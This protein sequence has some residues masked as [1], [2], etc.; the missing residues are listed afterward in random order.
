MASSSATRG[1]RLTALLNAR[2][3][4]SVELTCADM[5]DNFARRDKQ[6]AYWR[7]QISELDTRIM[8]RQRDLEELV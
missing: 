5:I 1:E 8:Q 7:A 3:R 4:A 2:E 6:M